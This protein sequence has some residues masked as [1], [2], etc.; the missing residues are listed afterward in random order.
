MV[1]LLWWSWQLSIQ[2]PSKCLWLI[3]GRRVCPFWLGATSWCP[4]D[5]RRVWACERHHQ[6]FYW[7]C[8]GSSWSDACRGPTLPSSNHTFHLPVWRCH[9]GRE[10]LSWDQPRWWL[11]HRCGS[12]IC[13]PSREPASLHTSRSPLTRMIGHVHS[14]VGIGPPSWLR[15]RCSGAWNRWHLI[16]MANESISGLF[17][18][19][20][21][22]SAT[23]QC[24]AAISLQLAPFSPLVAQSFS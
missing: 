22:V 5:S 11:A 16:R 10:R 17:P 14:P 24:L 19:A 15:G 23:P 21:P 2:S 13:G 12:H 6:S 18:Y 1:T 3:S 7:T 8:L 9:L 4:S 20:S